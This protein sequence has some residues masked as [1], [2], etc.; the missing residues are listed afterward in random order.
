M[1]KFT[2][3]GWGR[4]YVVHEKDVARVNE[5]IKEINPFEFAYMSN[6]IVAPFSEYPLLCNVQDFD[7]VDLDRLTA[8][9]WRGGIPIF[10][11]DN[12]LDMIFDELKTEAEV[13]YF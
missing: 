12:G 10:C 3:N 6:V 9:C 7:V 11:L 4:I 1:N 5:I 13:G 8:R 2:K